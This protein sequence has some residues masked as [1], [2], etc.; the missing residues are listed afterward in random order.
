MPR[1]YELCNIYLTK[2]AII[3]YPGTHSFNQP[4]HQLLDVSV[5]IFISADSSHRKAERPEE[6]GDQIGNFVK[7]S[8]VHHA[9]V[10]SV[11]RMKDTTMSSAAPAVCHGL[12]SYFILKQIVFFRNI[13]QL[14]LEGDNES[15]G[16]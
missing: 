13:G 4:T 16:Y 15:A 7:L 5:S 3:F 1:R 14:I 11:S 6:A 8:S 9:P 2:Q 10:Q 12:N